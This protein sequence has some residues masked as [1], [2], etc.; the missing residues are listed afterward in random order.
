VAVKCLVLIVALA[1]PIATL[2]ESPF[3][4]QQQDN[5]THLEKKEQPAKKQ[6]DEAAAESTDNGQLA[7]SDKLFLE[8]LIRE[9]MS[10]I[11]LANMALEKS[12]N[13]DVK[14]YA[15]TKILAADPEMRDGAEQL[16]RQYGVTPPTDLAERQ[17]KVQDELSKKSGRYFDAAYMSYEAGQQTNDTKLVKAELDSTKNSNVKSYVEK[18]KTPVDEAASTAT[19]VSKKIA[20]EMTAYRQPVVPT[21]SA[22]D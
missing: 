2:G 3:A 16:M 11:G 7:S 8:A 5:G 13:A 21:E 14:D 4:S 10:E 17:V 9:D 20:T 18:E 15:R 6:K 1:V 22:K 12:E 19:D